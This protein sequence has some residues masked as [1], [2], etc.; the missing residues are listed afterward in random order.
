MLSGART[1]GVLSILRPLRRAGHRRHRRPPPRRRRRRRRPTAPKPARTVPGR[2]ERSPTRAG[3]ITAKPA[4]PRLHAGVDDLRR[5]V[6]PLR[7]ADGAAAVESPRPPRRPARSSPLP[8]RAARAR[9]ARPLRQRPGRGS[10]V[11][12]GAVQEI[13]WAANQSSACPTSTVAD[14]PPSSRPAMTARERSPSPCTAPTCSAPR[15]TP[16]NSLGLAG[17]GRWVTI[18]SNPE[19]AYMT[20]AGLRLDTSPPMIP[21]TC[22]APLA[23][24]AQ[25]NAGYTVRHPLG[26]VARPR[27]RADAAAGAL[28][29][30]TLELLAETGR[31]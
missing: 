16:R 31:P 4:E 22:R 21:P 26:A 18:F 17:I 9:H 13:V 10:D 29:S 25:D 14:T 24:T 12:A 2:P 11:R 15:R 6:D 3:S 5:Q 1:E 19:H 30:A 7:A 28:A 23:P 27:R 8:A 20:V